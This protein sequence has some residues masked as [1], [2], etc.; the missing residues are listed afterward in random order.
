MQN[1]CFPSV[2]EHVKE[3]SLILKAQK[4]L[5]V[6]NQEGGPEAPPLAADGSN[7][8]INPASY[9]RRKYALGTASAGFY[10][11]AWNADAV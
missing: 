6:K 10:R 2:Q 8:Y 9:E 11:A 4:I 5:F 1:G 3:R 7:S